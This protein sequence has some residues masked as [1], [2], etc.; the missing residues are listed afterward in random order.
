MQTADQHRVHHPLGSE[1]PHPK[2]LTFLS[3]I[4]NKLEESGQ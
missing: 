4:V 1:R 3:C 2:M